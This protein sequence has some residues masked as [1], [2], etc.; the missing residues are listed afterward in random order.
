MTSPKVYNNPLLTKPKDIE[1][2]NLLKKE[3]KLTIWMKFNELQENSE[4]WLNENRNTIHDQ[5]EKYN[6]DT[7]ITEKNHMDITDSMTKR[8]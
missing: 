3:F 4:R 5:N 8:K 6:K 7:E 2:Y 1:I